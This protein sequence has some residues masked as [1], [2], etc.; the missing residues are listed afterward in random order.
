[1]GGNISRMSA[2]IVEA[3]GEH[4]YVNS[5]CLGE[6]ESIAMWQIYGS[7]GFGVAVKSWRVNTGKRRGFR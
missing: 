2:Q 1:M 7:L 6:S 5:W 3:A 4:L